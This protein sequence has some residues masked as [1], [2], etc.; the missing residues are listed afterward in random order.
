MRIMVMIIENDSNNPNPSTA[1]SLAEVEAS[2][3]GG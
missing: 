1:E 3:E 2:Q